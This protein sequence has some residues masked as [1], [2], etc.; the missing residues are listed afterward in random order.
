VPT[1]EL[2]F[3]TIICQKKDEKKIV[4]AAVAAGAPGV[5][6]LDGR[7]TGVR[8]KLGLMGS[9]VEAE[10]AILLLALP[11]AITPAVVKAVNEAAS[12]NKPGNGFM[13]VQKAQ[14]ILGYL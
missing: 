5:T 1:Q 13:C 4:E 6:C 10:K 14:Q 9:I 7:G 8:Q 2:D 3:L 12:L 11:V